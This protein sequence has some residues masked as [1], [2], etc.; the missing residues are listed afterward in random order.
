[1]CCFINGILTFGFL[2]TFQQNKASF[3]S[4]VTEENNAKRTF[5][6]YY[7]LSTTVFL[8]YL[9]GLII[10]SQA[11]FLNS[12]FLPLSPPSLLYPQQLPPCLKRLHQKSTAS[13]YVNRLSGVRSK[14]VWVYARFSSLLTLDYL[15]LMEFIRFLSRVTIKYN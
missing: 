10:R 13:F 11:S 8:A 5:S 2:L 14:D 9:S 1:M 3:V 7:L 12:S 6:C 15:L 4:S